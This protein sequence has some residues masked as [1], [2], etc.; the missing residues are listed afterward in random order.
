M[1]RLSKIILG[2]R[3]YVL[4]DQKDALDGF[5]KINLRHSCMDHFGVQTC[6]SQLLGMDPCLL[7]ACMICLLLVRTC[8]NATQ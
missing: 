6:H 7:P 3:K 2:A 4:N 5:L 1:A 8:C